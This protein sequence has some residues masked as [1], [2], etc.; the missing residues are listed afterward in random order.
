MELLVFP[1]GVN[2]F[3]ITAMIDRI[4]LLGVLVQHIITILSA[5]DLIS[6]G[7]SIS[8]K[9]SQRGNVIAMRFG[10]TENC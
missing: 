8:D 4:V 5:F 1:L 7:S 6:I 2:A 9:R 3:L 10:S